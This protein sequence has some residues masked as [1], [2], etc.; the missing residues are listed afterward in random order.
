MFVAERLQ[1]NLQRALMEFFG[2]RIGTAISVYG[3]EI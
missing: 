2:L 1:P 3:T